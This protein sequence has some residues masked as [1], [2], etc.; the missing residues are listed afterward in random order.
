[1]GEPLRVVQWAT[2]NIGARA[3]RGIVEHPSMELV[4]VWV[5]SD[6][7]AGRDAGDLCGLPPTGVLATTD[8]DELLALEPDAI[9]H[10]P[11]AFDADELCALLAS[12]A[13]VVT[14]RGELIRPAS[15]PDLAARVNDACLVGGSS[16]HGTGSSPGFITEAVPFVLSSLQ[17]RLD[18]LLI[19]EFADLSQR[20]SPDLLFNIMGFGRPLDEVD[21]SPRNEHL[22]QSFGPS[23][24]LLGDAMGIPLDT[25]VAEGELAAT[26]HRTEI[27]AGTLEA[28]TVGGMRT[29]ISGLRDGEP[30]ISFRATWFCAT[31]TEPRWDVLPT[32]W[33]VTIEGDS[34]MKVDLQLTAGLDDMAGYTANRVVNAVPYVVAAAPGIVTTLDLPQ[35]VPTLG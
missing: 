10:L 20:P 15:V 9:V 19:D 8:R 34:P 3:L 33:R 31:E 26:T 7:K 29:T 5:S 32:G 1:M 28:G 22:R 11:R 2:G 17:R 30:L 14:G 12:G 18:S 27:A 24:Q 16:L 6:A 25:V 21:G 4:G 13:N 35:I 23:L